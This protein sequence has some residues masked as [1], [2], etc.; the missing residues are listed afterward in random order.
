MFDYLQK[1]NTLPQNLRTSVSSPAAM[2]VISELENKYK[3]DLASTVMKVMVKIIPLADLSIYFVSDFSL[4]QELAKKLT[5]DL[6]ERLFFPVANYLGYN[7]SY[8]SVLPK[9]VIATAPNPIFLAADKVIKESGINFASADL[10]FRFK[11][12]LNTYLK[13]VR[14]RVDA[15][16][17][18]NKEIISGGLGLDHKTIDKIFKICDEIR[19]SQTLPSGVTLSLPA[20]E[21]VAKPGL[22]KIR[23][24]YEKPGGARDIPYD[25]KAAIIKGEVKKP[26]VPFNLPIPTESQEKLLAKPVEGH[27]LPVVAPQIN[28]VKKAEPKIILPVPPV[29][30]AT[31]KIPVPPVAAVAASVEVLKPLADSRLD[32]F[33]IVKPPERKAT[34]FNK[35]F[36]AKDAAPVITPEIKKVVTPAVG[37][38][39]LRAEAAISQTKPVLKKETNSPLNSDSK[40]TPKVMGPLEELRYLDVVNFRRFGS[41]PT[42]VTAKIESKIKLLE[43]DGY[44]KMISGVSAWRESPVVSLY[45]KMGQEALIKGLTFKQYAA[46]GQASGVNNNFLLWEEVEAIMA[47]NSRLMF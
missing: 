41:S 43:K 21:T 9:T 25:L 37:M 2:A 5:A 28:L 39:S 1:F 47:L 17:T 40:N 35:M 30:P 33:K 13:G 29:I 23:E 6:K 12:I 11:N 44:D 16:L 32:Q 18:L 8:S 42:E 20:A 34:I 22:E 26:V 38:A 24:L 7:A 15:R 31:S 36:S 3:I 14:S 4:D 27:P 19:A 45:L 46:E 10:S